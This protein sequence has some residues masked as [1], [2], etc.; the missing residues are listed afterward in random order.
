[1]PINSPLTIIF[2]NTSM[3]FAASGKAQIIMDPSQATTQHTAVRYRFEHGECAAILQCDTSEQ[4]TIA[5]D[6][7]ATIGRHF[8][9]FREKDKADVPQFCKKTLSSQ[10][11]GCIIARKNLVLLQQSS[12][13][14]ENDSSFAEQPKVRALALALVYRDTVYY[15]ELA[16]DLAETRALRNPYPYTEPSTIQV[17]TE[18]VKICINTAGL[19]VIR[20]VIRPTEI[21]ESDV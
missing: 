11:N 14:E 1:M 18:P 5:S 19:P 20:P 6:I 12:K 2:L 17:S 15:S 7:V 4:H 16:W 9:P 3:L 21:A 8:P 13:E 10:I